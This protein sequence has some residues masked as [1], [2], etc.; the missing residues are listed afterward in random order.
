MLYYNFFMSFKFKE[1]ILA[2][3]DLG[4]FLMFIQIV[5]DI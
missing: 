2:I 4:F 1:F 3:E 5:L